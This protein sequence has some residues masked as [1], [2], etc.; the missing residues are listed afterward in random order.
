MTPLVRD[1]GAA[2]RKLREGHAWSQEHLAEMAGL[3]RS[4]V[5][6][7]ERG[8]TIVSIVTLEKLARAF[9]VSIAAL[10]PDH[11]STVAPPVDVE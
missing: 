4:F 10:L 7:I 5:G 8:S 6:E 3:N 11:G 2:V 9:D 1:L